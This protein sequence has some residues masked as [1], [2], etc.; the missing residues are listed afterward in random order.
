MYASVEMLLKFCAEKFSSECT[1][2]KSR[3][4]SGEAHTFRFCKVQNSHW[5]SCHFT[6]WVP[7]DR[8]QFALVDSSTDKF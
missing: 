8:I 2:R 7:P 5:L 1:G 4:K 6:Q 3:E